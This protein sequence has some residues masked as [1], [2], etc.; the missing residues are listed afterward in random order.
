M[1]QPARL[2]GS[3]EMKKVPDTIDKGGVWFRQ[4]VELRL[5][6]QQFVILVQSSADLLV[7][8][9]DRAAWLFLRALLVRLLLVFNPARYQDIP[10]LLVRGHETVLSQDNLHFDYFPR[11]VPLRTTS[12]L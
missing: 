6:Q 1:L 4:F 9:S 8:R 5:V 12:N 11:S 3:C 7:L 2:L 10:E